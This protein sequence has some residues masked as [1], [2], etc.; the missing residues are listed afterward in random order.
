[1][2]IDR[3]GGR[4]GQTQVVFPQPNEQPGARRLTLSLGPPI[5]LTPTG[6]AAIN[7]SYDKAMRPIRLFG[8]HVPALDLHDA[9]AGLGRR[10]SVT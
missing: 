5:P 10:A 3:P 7:V 9:E 6:E 2:I 1:M 4:T 8:C